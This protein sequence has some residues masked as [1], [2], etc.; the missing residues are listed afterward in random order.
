MVQVGQYWYVLN[1][2]NMKIKFMSV[3]EKTLKREIKKSKI[4]IKGT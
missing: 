1:V 3:C 4:K 2:I